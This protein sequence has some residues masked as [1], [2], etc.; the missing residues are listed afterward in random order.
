MNFDVVLNI[1][2]HNVIYVVVHDLI[3]NSY[4]MALTSHNVLCD[5]SLFERS[6]FSYDSIIIY[7]CFT[8]NC[9]HVYNDN[10]AN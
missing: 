10:Y 6:S 9:A 5:R 8:L 7:S 2:L 3:C 1:V 4:V